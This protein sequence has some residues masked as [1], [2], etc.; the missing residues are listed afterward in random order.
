[1]KLLSHFLIVPPLEL[2]AFFF[3][4]VVVRPPFETC[5]ARLPKYTSVIAE[6]S[7]RAACTA[8][9][10]FLHADSVQIRLF[11]SYSLSYFLFP[12]FSFRVVFLCERPFLS[13][14]CN[15]STELRFGNVGRFPAQLCFVLP[16]VRL[17]L[18]VRSRPAV[19]G[20]FR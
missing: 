16:F 9:C 6:L 3:L 12:V 1:M 10:Y 13:Y 14:W 19:A 11:F 2:A 17:F 5:L 7:L 18:L 8:A 15:E 20:R 4:S